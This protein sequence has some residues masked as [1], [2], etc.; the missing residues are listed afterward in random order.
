MKRITLQDIA[1]EAG[2]HATTVSMALRRHPRIPASTRERIHEIAT[3][4]G[5]SPDPILSALNAYRFGRRRPAYQATLAWINDGPRMLNGERPWWHDDYF[6]SAQ[7]NARMLG[8][9]LEEFCLPELK[10]DGASISR[11]LASRNIPGLIIA[12]LPLGKTH[13]LDLDWKQFSAIAIGY[14]LISPRLHLVTNHQYRTMQDMI[15]RLRSLGKQRIGLVCSKAKD[16]R[17][18]HAWSAMFWVDYHQQPASHQVPPLLFEGNLKAG[19]LRSWHKRHAP[20]A[21]ACDDLKITELAMQIGLAPGQEI[22]IACT[23]IQNTA[24]TPPHAGMD[25]NGNAIGAAAVDIL[26]GMIQRNER[27]IPA[28][29][30]RTLIESTWQPGWT[31][32]E[33]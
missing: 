10:M 24:G 20:D 2:V 30:N 15:A 13:T 25:Q 31:V 23:R 4:L 11:M 5:Y 16:A 14:S 7:D 9:K 32:I 17:V 21:I 18:N 27:G 26:A 33:A 19:T 29:P 1:R 3:R 12:P 8:Y 28:I 6:L 22:A